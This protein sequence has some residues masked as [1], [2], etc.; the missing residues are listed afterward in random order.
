MLLS[1][2]RPK[3]DQLECQPL[4]PIVCIMTYYLCLVH[5]CTCMDGHFFGN[6]LVSSKL[7]SKISLRSVTWAELGNKGKPSQTSAGTWADLGKII[8]QDWLKKFAYILP[9]GRPCDTILSY[10]IPEHVD[11]EWPQEDQ[12]KKQSCQPHREV[13]F[14]LKKEISGTK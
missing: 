12:R 5:A 2:I 1:V 10:E 6:Q 13:Y 8:S 11:E 14:P 4:M 3:A 7:K 9:D